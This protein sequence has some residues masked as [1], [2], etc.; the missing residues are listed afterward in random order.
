MKILLERYAFRRSVFAL[1]TVCLLLQAAV[2]DDWP[3]WRGPNWNDRSGETGLLTEWPKDGPKQ[4]WV[5]SASGLGYAGFAVVGEQLFTMGLEDNAEFALCLD[6]TTG[7]EIWRQ[8]VGT[9]FENNWGD[10]PRSTPS[11]DGDYVY[12]MTAA[13]TLACLKKNDGQE[14]WKVQMQ[15]FGGQV[16][17]WGYSESPLVDEDRVVC[18]PGGPKGTMVALN[19]LTGEKIWQSPAFSKAKDGVPGE[20]AKAHYSSMI[21]IQWN[22]QRQYVQLTVLA[23]IGV[24]PEDGHEL[25]RS[26]W[27]GRTAVI[28]SPIFDDGQIYVTSGYNIGSK[29]IQ[30]ADDNSAS[31]KWFSMAM[32]NQHGGVILVDKF[33]YG[34]SEKAFVCQDRETGKMV[35]AERKIGKGATSFAD[36]MFYHVQESDGKVMLFSADKKTVN[37]KGSFT[38]APQTE[39]R[40]KAGR[41]WVHPVIAN[42]KLYLRDQE[43][44]YCYEIKAQ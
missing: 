36:G 32:Q 17:D 41:I 9:K 4:L 37:I 7:T 38:L 13:G 35:W 2:A 10:G 5:N 40:A 34:S 33:F 22:D 26:D 14:V 29:L 8:P 3:H 23:A 44:V 28:P 6:A 1:M 20:P 18:T 11:V 25:W 16:P 42:G 39:R 30:L 19:K 12:V 43:M 15:D 27:A 24:S 21:P 31:E